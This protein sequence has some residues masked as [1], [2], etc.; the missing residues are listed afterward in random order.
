MKKNCITA[1][2]E[3][4][5]EAIS[6]AGAETGFARVKDIRDMLGVKTPSVTGALGLLSKNGLIAHEKYG[7][8]ELT[9]K[10]K[11]TAEDIKKRHAVLKT[12]LEEILKVSPSVAEED[13]CKMEH[14]LSAETF[15]LLTKFVS[16]N[17]K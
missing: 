17:V 13:A 4:Y 15:K 2:M 8:I 16:K 1:S 9:P 3:D 10:G 14:S 6:L 12:F 5:L 7:H 11:K